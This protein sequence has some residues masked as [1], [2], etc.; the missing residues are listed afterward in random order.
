MILKINNKR[1]VKQ[2]EEINL[3]QK[4]IEKVVEVLESKD[5][6]LGVLVK[7]IERAK[8]K[9]RPLVADEVKKLHK[10]GEFEVVGS[11]KLEGGF[12]EVSIFDQIEEYK[13]A[14][15]ERKNEEQ[16]KN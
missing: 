3:I 10:M 8:D 2:F 16:T 15:R 11:S 9:V 12:V 4:D 14:L 1:I 7:K 5:A 6:E 13:K